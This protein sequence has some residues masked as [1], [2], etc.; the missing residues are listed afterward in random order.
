MWICIENIHI[1]FLNLK[2]QTSLTMY[3][4]W[5]HRLNHHYCNKPIGNKLISVKHHGTIYV[6]QN[7]G[8]KNIGKFDELNANYQI[9]RAQIIYKTVVDIHLPLLGHLLNFSPSNILN[10]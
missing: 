3:L 10:M 1:A 5:Y 6:A 9:F 4:C 8:R 7:I 2:M